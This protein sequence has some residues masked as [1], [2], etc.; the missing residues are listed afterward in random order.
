MAY[1]HHYCRSISA[2]PF[3]KE[4]KTPAAV[5]AIASPRLCSRSAGNF[6]RRRCLLDLAPR[7]PTPGDRYAVS[8]SSNIPLSH[9][10]DTFWLL[11]DLAAEQRK[12]L[13]ALPASPG[14]WQSAGIGGA[15]AERRGRAVPTIV[16]R[17]VVGW[18]GVTM[19]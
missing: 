13:R 16:R 1:H 15:L 7:P 10:S 3:G 6:Q 8:G 19:R 18:C 9:E 11:E 2:A 12:A 5:P 4:P 17:D 14:V